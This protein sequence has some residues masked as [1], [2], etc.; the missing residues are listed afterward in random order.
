MWLFNFKIRDNEQCPCGSGKSYK[1]CCKGKKPSASTSKKPPEVLIMERMRA[2]MPKCCMHPDKA[3]CNGRI[4]RAHALQ[5]NKIISLLAGS[6]RHVY[7]LNSKRQPLLIPLNDG[8]SV[9][10][11]KVDKVSAND[12]T[13]ETCFC[14][15]HDSTVFAIIE[16]DAPDFDETRDDMKF[17]YAYKAFIFEYYKQWVSMDIYRQC[18]RENP[19]AFISTELVA[20]YRTLQM[21]MREFEPAK[22]Y[23]DR[24]I[25]SGTFE[26]IVTCAIKIPYPIKF[27][28]YAY[29]ALDFDLN[30][31]RIKHTQ[32]GIM[33][34]VAITVFPELTQSWLLVSCLENEKHIYESFFEQLKTATIEKLQ[35]YFNLILPL[36]SENVVLASSLWTSWNESTQEGYTYYANL[37]GPD[38]ICASYAIKMALVNAAKDKSGSAYMKNAEHNL[39][40]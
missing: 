37:N 33:H 32:K 10:I 7:M 22:Q 8:I 25:L 26:G 29:I 3:H 12:A 27:A 36:Y 4:K 23:F 21:R 11:V 6:D 35:Y 18:F 40:S 39:F 17:I 34:R 31:K 13:T 2:F 30:G 28:D 1:I 15:L 24:Q 38:A 9:P 20:R 19:T 14:D 16:K 5:N